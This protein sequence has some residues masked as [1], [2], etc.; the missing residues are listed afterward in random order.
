MNARPSNRLWVWSPI[1]YLGFGLAAPVYGARMLISSKYRIGLPQRLTMYPASLRSALA[2][3]PNIWLHAVSVG[4]L[5]AASGL[6]QRL[7][8][9]FPEAQLAVSTVT[10]TG[11]GLAQKTPAIAAPFYLPL[12][13]YPLCRKTA[14][15]VKPAALIV[16]ETE[17]WPN[18]IRAVSAEGAPIYLVNA[19][20]SDKSASR[21]RRARRLFE[22]LLR[23]ID[24]V[25]AQSEED[26]RRFVEIGAPP[27]RVFTAGN[28]KFD[29][30]TPDG[31]EEERAR[32]RSLFQLR[33]DEILLLAGSTFAG[34]ETALAKL[35]AKL[36]AEGIPLRL[37]IAPR[38]VERSDTILSELAALNCAAIRRS[39]L[40][41]ETKIPPES[42]ILLDTI[43]EL[44]RAY[45]AADV[46]FI[47][48]SLHNRGGQNPIE[49]AVWSKPIVFGPHMQ[50]FRDVTAL[51]LRGE[52][53]IQVSGEDELT[54]AV[55][56]LCA[57]EDE[58]RRL[59]ASA[60]R[61]VEANRGALDRITCILDPVIQARLNDAC[62]DHEK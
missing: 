6:I 38:H 4:E 8:D 59:G 19:R 15:L 40:T 30:E 62:A 13:L 52:G 17:L 1:S 28:V 3:R 21:Y 50:N 25:L 22:P 53:A 10:N 2:Q 39:A 24:G 16:M 33:D 60:L 47:G 61:V 37:A 41:G 48:K 45:S 7:H 58:R 20:L 23:R 36:R 51:F 57:S 56:A 11:Q 46:V 12:D 27:E 54:E 26:A 34:E 29:V 35:T 31:V 49:P 5:Q 43:G 32:W 14:R 55:R 44:R 9:R 42:P 18:L